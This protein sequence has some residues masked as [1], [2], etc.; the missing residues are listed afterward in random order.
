MRI[1]TSKPALRWLAPLAVVVA[2]GGT[3]WWRPRPGRPSA[4]RRSRRAAAGRPAAVAR[5]TAC[6][7]RWSQQADLGIPA[8]PGRAART[9]RQLT[10]LI[11]GHPH[12]AGLVRRHRTRP[13]RRPRHAGRD[14][15]HHQRPRRLDLVQPGQDGHPPHARR[16][17]RPGAP[18]ERPDR[19]AARPRRR[20]PQ[21]CLDAIAPTHRRSAP[22]PSV[23]VAGRDAYELVLD[24][25]DDGSLIEQVRIAIDGETRQ[26]LRVQVFARRRP[27][28]SSRSATRRST[29]PG[30]TTA[31][32]S[33]TRRP[34]PR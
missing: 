12:A 17:R 29:S 10:S 22:T 28:W 30:P 15:H 21:R 4:A 25:N 32:S 8:I 16:A 18:A 26:P 7:A 27:S 20:P 13:A 34:A 6:P 23:E 31:S 9:A 2:V 11:S 19:C 33:S 1:L 5:S 3:S 14:R 24:P